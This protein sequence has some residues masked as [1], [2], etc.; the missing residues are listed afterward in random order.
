MTQAIVDFIRELYGTDQFIALHEPRFIG[1]EKTYVNECIDSTFVSSI[2]KYVD[3]FE[4]ELAD[5]VGS[6]FAVAVVNGTQA[7]HIALKMAG[8]RKGDEVITQSLTFVATANAIAYCDAMPLFLDV[9]RDTLGLSDTALKDYLESNATIRNGE[10]FNNKT[11]RRISAC[12][13]MHS[14]GQ[15]CRI[16]SIESICSEYNITLIEDAAESLGSYYNDRHTG[17]FGKMGIFSFNG[18]KIVTTGG[19]GMIV[20]DDERLAKQAKHLTTTAKIPHPWEFNH[21][22]VGYNYRMPN[23]NAALGV[24][25]LEMLPTFIEKKRDL[26]ERYR[27]FFENREMTFMVEPPGARSNYWLNAVLVD[28]PGKKESFLEETNRAGVM[29][30]PI[31]TPM[32]MLPMYSHCQAGPLETT[33]YLWERLVNLP[34]SVPV[35]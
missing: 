2:G 12:V 35:S 29:T 24:G 11:G 5:F 30:R 18:N 27:Q 32:H 23:L 16:E 20:T 14:F 6:R 10:T 1:N 31:W 4:K 15:P 9:D 25:Q 22:Q 3:R 21:D 26:A 13:P 8:V 28:D 33:R 19:G 34:S 17:T 7:L